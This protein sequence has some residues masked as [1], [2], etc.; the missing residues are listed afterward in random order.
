MV[1]RKKSFLEGVFVDLLGTPVTM[2]TGIIITPVYFKYI[3]SNQYGIWTSALDYI[4][5]LTLMNAGINIQIIQNLSS[6]K[7]NKSEVNLSSILLYQILIILIGTLLSIIGL[8][9]FPVFNQINESENSSLL[10]IISLNLILITGSLNGWFN[11]V[12]QG[13]NRVGLS[14]LI[15]Y[16]SKLSYQLF[17]VLL[18]VYGFKLLSFSTAYFFTNILILITYLCILHKFIL[19]IFKK[20]TINFESLKKNFFFSF[21]MFIGGISYY[22]L[23]FTD[24]LIIA[25]YLSPHYVTIYV[26]TIKTSQILKFITPKLLS[27]TFPTINQLIYEE[28]FSRL[29][30]LTIKFYKLSLRCGILFFILL[31]FFNKAFVHIWVGEKMYGG[32]FITIC[33][34]S[35][36]FKESLFVVFSNIIFATK[37][38]K[39]INYILFIEAL[40]NLI[41]SIVLVDKYGINGVIISTVLTSCIFSLTYSILKTC[42]LIK[43]DIYRLISP[44]IVTILK[45]LPSI[46]CLLISNVYFNYEEN[47]FALLT[48]VTLCLFINFMM[49]EAIIIFKNRKLNWKNIVNKI[50]YEI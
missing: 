26:L 49:F 10:I 24:T 47:I 23:N 28:N 33:A 22:I 16:L 11:S 9:Y 42:D 19:E 30:E 32:Y 13:Q 2:I 12:I 38:I 25:N 14:N 3:N 27:S 45:S 1:S 4:T 17:P 5:L 48:S 31:I 37:D 20:F 21:K 50:I 36:C 40:L 43:L 29:N 44:T 41:L 34:A 7:K 39:Y 8:Y 15:N 35:I 46:I 6:F 18:M